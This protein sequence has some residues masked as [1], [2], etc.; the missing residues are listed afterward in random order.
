MLTEFIAPFKKA[1]WPMAGPLLH[2]VLFLAIVLAPGF[3]RLE[4]QT[5]GIVPLAAPQLWQRAEF[6][7]DHAPVATN[8]FDP[9]LIRLDATFTPPSGRSLTVPAFW[10][11]DFS[12]ALTNGAEVLTP[13]GSPHWRIRFTP[14][15]PGDYTLSLNIQTNGV[16]AG[17]PVVMHFSVPSVTPSGQHGYVRIAPDKR[18]FETTD[19]RPLRLVGA[20]VCWGEN[21]GTFNYDAWFGAMR[22]TGENFARLWM[23]PW[24]MGLE[25]MPGRL[26]NYDLRSAWQLD[27]IF[28]LADQSGI[29]LLLCFDHHGMFQANN[30]NWGGSNNFWNT[31]AYNQI[32]GGPC[33]KPNDFFT[34]ARA[35][36]IY[37]KRLRYLIGRYSYSPRLLAWQF[38]NEIDNVFGPLNGDDVV[39]WHREMG[40]WLHAHDPYGHLVTTSLTGGSERPEIWSLPEMDF[41]VY[42]SYNESAPG[43]GMATLARSFVKDYGKP[44]MIGEF[45]VDSRSWNIA[46]DPYLRGFRQAV[47]SGALGGSVGTAMLWWW[48]DIHKD[49]V[50]PL[51]AAMNGILR[52]AGWQSGIW[53]PADFVSA[54]GPPVDLARAIPNG[55]L[56]NAQPTLN[57]AWRLQH[58]LSGK[59][60][61]ADR[62]AA[63]QASQ[64]LMTYLLGRHDA[65]FQRPFRITGFFGE[66]AKLVLHVKTVHSDAELIVRVDGAEVLHTNFIRAAG[67]TATYRDIN[68]DF[69]VN[70]PAGK[71]VIEIANDAGADWVL[72]DSLKFEQV[73]P[74]EF[75]GG[76]YFAPEA[77]GLRN[78]KKAVLYVYSPW[79]VY[80]AGA[81]RY[82]P[83]LLTG[84]SL[85]LTNWPAGKF[86]VQWFEPSTGKAIGTT[87]AATDGPILTLPLPAFRD[88]LAAIVTPTTTS[89]PKK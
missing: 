33:E 86:N 39:A 49:D 70:F 11:L 61:L 3:S 76:W 77:V 19:G 50:Y 51:F 75:A 79:V 18:Y 83:P 26:N 17:K 27:Y 36:T 69:T 29:Y 12:R 53:I 88:D 84:Q 25:H 6:R 87:E 67:V 63:D 64:N 37:E 22:N 28:D 85:Q 59:L 71:R 30:R 73:L 56:F 62:L 82:N 72:I 58:K 78:E 45:G 16:A 81:L 10:Y 35:K 80:P 46:S 14:T 52:S 89:P 23:A 31:N 42:H 20:N 24:F 38:F 5:P 66:K 60:A 68:Q 4:A 43:K 1:A 54:G 34:N 40:Q 41:S 7:V 21:Q 57:S 55:E 2:R 48:Q 65:E 15:E 74:A 13:V 9:D 44:M 47:W 8:C 32:N